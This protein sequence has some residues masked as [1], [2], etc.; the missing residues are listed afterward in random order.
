M[1]LRQKGTW[2]IFKWCVRTISR[3][4]KFQELFG[5]KLFLLKNIRKLL[6]NSRIGACRLAGTLLVVSP[7]PLGPHV[8]F[9]VLSLETEKHEIGFWE[10]KTKDSNNKTLKLSSHFGQA[11]CRSIALQQYLCSEEVWKSL[12]INMEKVR[13]AEPHLHGSKV[14]SFLRLLL[15]FYWD[16]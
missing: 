11:Q 15:L 14:D 16:S 8:F 2:L 12:V 5:M 3:C 6:W 13:R 1:L 9:C 7:P 4:L 10:R